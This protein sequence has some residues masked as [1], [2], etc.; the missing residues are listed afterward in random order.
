MNESDEQFQ[1]TLVAAGTA[2]LTNDPMPSM[3]HFLG[4]AM[5]RM[6][7]IEQRTHERLMNENS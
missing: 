7:N 4:V 6:E 2:A 1:D 5:A 3:L